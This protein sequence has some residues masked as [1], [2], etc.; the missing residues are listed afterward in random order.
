MNNMGLYIG[1]TLGDPDAINRHPA[2][3]VTTLGDVMAALRRQYL[4][5]MFF[6]LLGVAGGVT[7]HLTSPPQ[8]YTQATVLI[9]DRMSD[10]TE[11]I[12]SSTPLVRNDTSLLNEI[13]VLKS[14]QL[15]TEVVRQTDLH[16]SGAFLDPPV[17]LASR[18][19]SSIKTRVVDFLGLEEDIP[20]PVPMTPEQR[21]EA[22]ILATAAKLQ[23]DMGIERIGLSFSVE[24]SYVGT[25]AALAS[26]LVNTYAQAYLAD[27][28]NANLDSTR[29]TAEWMQERLKEIDQ[30]SRDVLQQ[31]A[32]LRQN[33]PSQGQRLRELAQ[34]AANL[35]ALSDTISARYEQVAIQGS[36]PVTNGRILTHSIVPKDA[37]LPKLWQN[38]SIFT[39]LGLMA[40]LCVAALRESGEQKFRVSS[41]VYTHTDQRFLGHLPLINL[42][43]LSDNAPPATREIILS[44][45]QGSGLNAA[46][47][48]ARLEVERQS[49]MRLA[50]HLFW[51]VL[52]P[53]SLFNET[54]HNIHST[55]EN[56]SSRRD[57]VAIAVTSMLPGEGKTMLAANY[58]NMLA[59]YGARTLLIDMDLTGGGIS[60]ALEMSDGPGI[61]QVLKGTVPMPDAIRKLP[62]TGLDVMPCL[63]AATPSFAG[64]ILYHQNLTVLIE[65][66]RN[67]YDCIVFDMP[68]LGKVS[69]VK[70]VLA[71]LDQ[72]LMVSEWGK[73]PRRLVTQYLAQEPEIAQQIVG[74]ALNKV[75]IGKLSKYARPGWPDSYLDLARNA[76]P[77]KTR[78]V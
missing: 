14:L 8:Y 65:E 67:R 63:A 50:P 43:E 44:K 66:L 70:V 76:R 11:E 45:A 71:Q 72:I 58:A 54:L 23:G 28:L 31:A 27:H 9:D 13:E 42:R 60:H 61:H 20:D 10:L 46:E 77:R 24:I 73:T 64:D 18:T 26:L 29:R 59:K 69:D 68:S 32:D 62:F 48:N 51:S 74:I 35:D 53:Q 56:G 33:D 16:N 22:R 21:E 2:N 1:D 17:S 40:G 57:C 47:E 49:V 39:I 5:L 25:N 30:S 3:D 7:H 12:S 75:D 36:F 37:A 55:V 4:P 52:A 15:A 38:L 78:R 19:V 6:A 41:D 34:R